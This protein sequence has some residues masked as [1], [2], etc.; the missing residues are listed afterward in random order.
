MPVLTRGH[1]PAAPLPRPLDRAAEAA[2][3]Q[4]ADRHLVRHPGL[5]R[6]RVNV[7]FQ[8]EALAAAFRVIPE[9]IKTLEELGL[10]SALA[11]LA[12]QPRGLVL[13]TG[14]TGSGKSTTLAAMI[15]EINRNRTDHILTIEDP[16][17]FVHR[18]KRCIVNQREI[19][20]DATSFGEALRGRA[21]PG[22]RRDPRRRDARP[23]DDLDRAHRGRDR[24]PRA[25]A[26]CTRRARRARSTAIIDVFPAE[27][28][29]QVRIMLADSLQGIVTQALLP[30]AD[31][32]G[33][34]AALEILLPDDA[35][36]NLIRQG[37][38]EQVYTIMQTSRG[39]GMQTMEQSL[40][41]LV[42]R[43]VITLEV[44]LGSL[45]PPRS[46]R[47]TARAQRLRRACR[48][49]QQRPEGHG[50][51]MSDGK[52]TP[53]W[54]KEISFRRKPEAA[55]PEGDAGSTPLWKK[56]VSFRK[57]SE[58]GTGGD[59]RRDADRRRERG[60]R[61][62]RRR[63]R[64]SR[65]DRPVCRPA[66]GAPASFGGAAERARLVDEAPRGGLR[67]TRRAARART[68][69]GA[70]GHAR[71]DRARTAGSRSSRRR[72]RRCPAGRAGDTG[73]P[74]RPGTGPARRARPRA[75]PRSACHGCARAA[76]GCGRAGAGAADRHPAGA[77]SGG[78][79][80]RGACRR[81][82][83]RPGARAGACSG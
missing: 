50:R 36:R 48:R 3:A 42:L 38:V 8:R 34:V 45:E 47:G 13:V 83:C 37:K 46:A 51:L 76:A 31:G 55:A 73:H 6:F 80:S 1:H 69:S 18:H 30:T 53:I 56:E 28:Q 39:R 17:E 65:P 72:R 78:A 63:D 52:N 75:R 35:I 15:D 54:K 32:N 40:A 41:N 58:A 59:A 22:P 68:R 25:S 77:S 24:P 66:R 4:A 79:G 5:A 23:G 61:R 9:E 70:R 49:A 60:C 67:A 20:V 57:K 64:R 12:M 16:I 11:E 29:E 33:R 26:P 7:Y 43:R 27:Q 81:R 21:P 14:P 2:R 74:C 71:S 62:G 19:G 82:A 44:A 10:P